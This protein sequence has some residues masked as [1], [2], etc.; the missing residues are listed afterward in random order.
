[1]YTIRTKINNSSITE[2]RFILFFYD[3]SNCFIQMIKFK[4]EH[5]TNKTKYNFY[6][7]SGIK[8][9]VIE[10]LEKPALK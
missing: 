5:L 10:L 2:S 9:R 4:E 7:S 6:I 8:N 1:M 3:K